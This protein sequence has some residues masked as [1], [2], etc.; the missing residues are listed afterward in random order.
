MQRINLECMTIIAFFLNQGV[1]D[2]PLG[3][4]ELMVEVSKNNTI[5]ITL[6]QVNMHNSKWY[7]L[8]I[9]RNQHIYRI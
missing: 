9:V 1:T 3:V 2:F 8:P 7:V 5:L 4:Q 6:R